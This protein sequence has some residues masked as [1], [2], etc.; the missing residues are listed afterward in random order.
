[1]T[2]LHL[3]SFSGRIWFI[4]ERKFLVEVLCW[5]NHTHNKLTWWKV[6]TSVIIISVFGQGLLIG[7]AWSDRA[8]ETSSTVRHGGHLR[9]FHWGRSSTTIQRAA[10]AEAIFHQEMIISAS[11]MLIGHRK[12]DG[13]P[14][15]K[16]LTT[17]ETDRIYM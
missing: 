14:L 16:Y 3:L 4:T 7:I 9:R 8:K 1:M 15:F 12:L 13:A 2:I 10:A 6:S 17:S 11:R 5:C